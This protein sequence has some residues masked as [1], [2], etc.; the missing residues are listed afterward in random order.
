MELDSPAIEQ[1]AGGALAAA[2]A[3]AADTQPQ[4]I[5]TAAA[6]SGQSTACIEGMYTRVHDQTMLIRYTRAP[7][8]CVCLFRMVARGRRY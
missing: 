1:A 5:S 6:D 8:V 3:P 2:A 4:L 7:C